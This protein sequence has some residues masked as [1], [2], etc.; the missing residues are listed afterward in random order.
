[1]S[2]QDVPVR[3][4][5][6]DF[7]GV[8]TPPIEHSIE[9]FCRNQGVGRRELLAAMAVV[10]ARYG[11][12]DPLAPLDIPLVGEDEWLREVSAELGGALRIGSLADTWFAGRATNLA[13]VEVLRE[14]RRRGT[15]VSLISNMVPTWDVHWRRMVDADELFDHIM[16]SFEV[17]YRKPAPEMFGLAAQRAGVLPAECV[18]VDDLAKNCAGAEAAGW[19]AVHFLDANSA[20]DQLHQLL[21]N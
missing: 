20:A 8:L 10:S 3:V 17:G 14:I 2:S 4:V 12:D 9:Q 16:L 5:W 7:G 21:E 18:L 6:S 15:G 11:V 13:W 19:R 1:M